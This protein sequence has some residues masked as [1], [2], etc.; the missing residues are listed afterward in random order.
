MENI[1]LN[2]EKYI[3]GKKDQSGPRSTYVGSGLHTWAKACV[4]RHAP[5]YVAK[6]LEA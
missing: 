5:V 2:E 4:C 1:T 3:F 6:V